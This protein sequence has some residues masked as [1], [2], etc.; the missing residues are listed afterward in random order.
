MCVYQRTAFVEHSQK[1]Q[2]FYPL[3][4]EAGDEAPSHAAAES[5]PPSATACVRLPGRAR[6]TQA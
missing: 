3:L 5:P 4:D 1:A 2:R 6:V